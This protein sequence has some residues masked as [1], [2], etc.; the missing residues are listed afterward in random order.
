MT[1]A[2]PPKKI[3]H[4][5]FFYE[6]LTQ[7]DVA[8]AFFKV[9]LPAYIQSK[10]DWES[11]TLEPGRFVDKTYRQRYS[12]VLY[13]VKV[14]G[15]TAYLYVL[16]EHKSQGDRLM[17]L[18]VMR[19]MCEIWQRHIEQGKHIGKGQGCLPMIYPLTYYHGRQ[20][21]YPYSTDIRDCF[22]DR[23]LAKMVFDNA[24]PLVDMTQYSDEELSQH[25]M[26]STFERIQK[27]IFAKDLLEE[28]K[29]LLKDSRFI[30]IVSEKDGDYGMQVLQYMI[31][32]G[33]SKH[34]DQFIDTLKKQ[35][36]EI[37]DRIMTIGQQLRQQ[38]KEIREHEIAREM[39]KE[40][41][42]VERVARIVK[43]P[44]AEV[45]QLKKH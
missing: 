40:G 42:S 28:I 33:E 1:K 6:S 43:L 17:P 24:F 3:T 34:A 23:A 2:T 16:T 11:L 5:L 39:L 14:S 37:G 27:H 12:D 32:V 13:S 21:P 9:Y 22:E 45:E 18:Q 8:L 25:G 30:Q 44:V 15:D 4:D 26:A 7:R 29:D 31:E 20:T 35:L 38:G 10:I 36:P 19:Y 41:D